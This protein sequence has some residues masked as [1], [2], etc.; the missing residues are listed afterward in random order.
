MM[1][2]QSPG[3]KQQSSVWVLCGK[4]A[5]RS[6]VLSTHQRGLVSRWQ[7]AAYAVYTCCQGIH[8]CGHRA[9]LGS[10][11]INGRKLNIGTP[12]GVPP[13][14]KREPMECHC[15]AGKLASLWCWAFLYCFC[16]GIIFNTRMSR[17]CGIRKVRKGAIKT[18]PE[19]HPPCAAARSDA[20]R[21][22]RVTAPQTR[23]NHI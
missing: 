6:M 4:G 15:G 19:D 8:H 16:Q 17:G 11:F 14:Q 12:A 22:D 13:A 20:G 18:G 21:P 5:E 7:V 9:T 23:T 3:Q 2:T 10:V 1:E